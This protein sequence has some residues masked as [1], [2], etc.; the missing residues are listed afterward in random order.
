[1]EVQFDIKLE[2]KDLFK[3]NM[4][5]GYTSSQGIISIIVP[6][7]IM[8]YA[9]F[10]GSASDIMHLI[11]NIALALLFLFYL[12][13]TYSVRSKAVLKKNAVLANTLHYC[14][15]EKN[16]KVTQ[17]E[18]SG[19]LEWDQ[20]YKMVS[21]K[22]YIYIFTSRINAYIIPIHQTDGQYNQIVEIAKEKLE[23][24]RVNMKLRKA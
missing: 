12:P 14:I 15:S 3:F 4:R 22:N 13:I 18:E 5:Q 23:K 19:E 9:I 17:G 6:I 1:M 24:Y 2:P 16:I 7:A 21:T 10:A 11:I 8:G 20:I